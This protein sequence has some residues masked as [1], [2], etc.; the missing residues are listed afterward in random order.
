[1]LNFANLELAVRQKVEQ[2]K[3]GGKK[4]HLTTCLLIRGNLNKH[5]K[6]L[7]DYEVSDSFCC[8]V[9]SQIVLGCT[10]RKGKRVYQSQLDS[11]SDQ[12]HR[13]NNSASS[14]TSVGPVCNALSP[15]VKL[16]QGGWT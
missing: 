1:M 7:D 3:L 5:H 14:Q 16:I 9:S 2:L 6:T 12:P 10:V 11:T 13:Y 4:P 15:P 8:I